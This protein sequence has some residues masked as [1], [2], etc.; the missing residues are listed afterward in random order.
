[1]DEKTE[2]L[3]ENILLAAHRVKNSLH[4]ERENTH[5]LKKD[6][7]ARVMKRNENRNENQ[8][9]SQTMTHQL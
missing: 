2:V 9:V 8:S 4:V 3:S 5:P 7:I 6:M 1:M